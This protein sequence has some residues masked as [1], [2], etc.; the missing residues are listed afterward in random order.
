[1]GSG[2]DCLVMIKIHHHSFLICMGGFT[3]W[4][5]VV[6]NCCV[7]G[8]GIKRVNKTWEKVTKKL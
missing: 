6:G 8:E 1:M 4:W 2:G 3:D 5:F 7:V